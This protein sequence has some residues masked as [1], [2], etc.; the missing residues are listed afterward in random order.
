MAYLW[1][2]LPLVSSLDSA[3]GPGMACPWD[4]SR[5]EPTPA[6]TPTALPRQSCSSLLLG[7]SLGPCPFQLQLQV[8][9]RLAL[10]YS[11]QP[12]YTPAPTGLPKTPRIHSLQ[13]GSSYTRSLLQE[14][15]RL[16][17]CLIH[18]DKYRETDKMRRHR[19]IFQT[20][21]QDETLEE[22]L[23]ETGQAIYQIK[24]SKHLL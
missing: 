22:E 7:L 1:E 6:T 18:I 14:Q 5:P 16:L 4:Y 19:N 17:F 11:L 13:R 15:G 10:Q 24:S 2:S 8:P 12:T 9:V 21:D 20:K 3:P 23:K